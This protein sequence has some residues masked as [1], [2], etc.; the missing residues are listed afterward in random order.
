[1]SA[2]KPLVVKKKREVKEK[3]SEDEEEDWSE[4]DRRHSDHER[5]QSPG[6]N[7]GKDSDSGRGEGRGKK[8]KKY[9]SQLLGCH[10]Q[11]ERK[12]KRPKILVLG[13]LFGS[14]LKEH[15]ICKEE[16]LEM[17]KEVVTLLRKPPNIKPRESIAISVRQRV[18]E[19][20]RCFRFGEDNTE[21]ITAQKKKNAAELQ[22]LQVE[23]KVTEDFMKGIESR[24]R[25]RKKRALLEEA[26]AKMGMTIEELE[27]ARAKF[28]PQKDE[29][30]NKKSKPGAASKTSQMRETSPQRANESPLQA[31]DE[32][33]LG[34]RQSYFKEDTMSSQPRRTFGDSF[35]K[36]ST[37]DLLANELKEKAKLEQWRKAN[38]KVLAV[39]GFQDTKEDVEKTI[40]NLSENTAEQD[41][42]LRATVAAHMEQVATVLHAKAELDAKLAKFLSTR[43]FQEKVYGLLLEYL[44]TLPPLDKDGLPMSI[45]SLKD[46]LKMQRRRASQLAI[47]RIRVRFGERDEKKDTHVGGLERPVASNDAFLG[48]NELMRVSALLRSCMYVKAWMLLY[49]HSEHSKAMR[50]IGAKIGFNS[51]TSLRQKVLKV[52]RNKCAYT[53]EMRVKLK[54]ARG[55][56]FPQLF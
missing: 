20:R 45:A 21:I 30:E 5:A 38:T 53:K 34:K 12:K 7:S 17:I 18:A 52:L 39:L 31:G 23:L 1:M 9:W 41:L 27:A 33:P 36:S 14:F 35:A 8:Y 49:R 54:D 22:L 51:S 2:A 56:Q 13:E 16:R 26:A 32:S 46:I 28:T 40:N 29:K 4:W 50:A 25:R 11:A 48:R 44:N 15:D 6:A 37:F 47:N 24:D 3:N 19:E 42:E 43:S 10:I 55:T